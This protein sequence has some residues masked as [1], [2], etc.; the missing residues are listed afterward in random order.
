MK[1]MKARALEN[2]EE[3]LARTGYCRDGFIEMDT[4]MQR[5]SLTIIGDC[6][7]R[8]SQADRDKFSL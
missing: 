4:E 1:K 6:S 5:G 8:A 3:E 2:L 7:E